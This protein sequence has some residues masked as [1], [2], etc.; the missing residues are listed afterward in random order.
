MFLQHHHRLQEIEMRAF[1]YILQIILLLIVSGCV[2][3]QVGLTKYTGFTELPF[4]SN[5][6]AS[7]QI[8]EIYSSPKKVEITF[9]PRIPWDQATVSDGWRIS[10]SETE[11]IK[12]SFVL[13]IAK[14]L[15]GT[16]GYNSEKK[17][18]VD[19]TETQ[20]RILPKNTI[21]AAVAKSIQD[22]PTLSRLLSSY[23]QNGTHFDVITQTLNATITLSVV[24]SSGAAIDIDFEVMRKLNSEFGLKFDRGSGNEKTLSG[25]N[26]VVGIHYDT[27]M[28]DILLLKT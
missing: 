20:T 5:A 11:A 10:A 19:F 12:S 17:V 26:L 4:P 2:T 6:Y 27:E 8:I 28:I 15:K 21:Y 25:R 9:D 24:D 23:R 7:G 14:I 3:S 16:A 22:D 13:E 1:A 18:K